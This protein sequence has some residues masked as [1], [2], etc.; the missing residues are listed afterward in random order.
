MKFACQASCNYFEGPEYY[1]FASDYFETWLRRALGKRVKPSEHWTRTYGKDWT[2]VF[3][4][5][6]KRGRKRPKI[7]YGPD[8]DRREKTVEWGI[9]VDYVGNK[10]L[11]PKSYVGPIRQFLEGIMIVLEK[12][13]IDTSKL[14]KDLPAA[15]KEFCS[16]R[17]MISEEATA[18]NFVDVTANDF[19]QRFESA[20]KTAVRHR[21]LPKWNIPKN[22]GKLVDEEG[23]TWETCRFAPLRL[24]VMS[25]TS[26]HGRALPLV[27]QIELDIDLYDK[28]YESAATKI[29]ATGND[30]D[31]DGWTELVEE[32]F[33]KRYPRLANQLDSDSETSTCVMSV[34]SVDACKKL[35][36]LMWSLIY[37]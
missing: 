10:S 21:R 3:G 23:G 14:S 11:D 24:L 28:Q 34:E 37:G 22:I 4:L 9:S 27:W 30:P 1:N 26:S 15:I 32:E 8:V 29:K 17:Y 13:E 6:V 5:S 19:F 18:D 7:V 35:L 12:L 36:E 2:L 31:G 20:P 25:G 16:N 33:A